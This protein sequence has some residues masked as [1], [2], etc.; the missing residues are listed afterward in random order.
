M[1][2][3]RSRIVERLDIRIIALNKVRRRLADRSLHDRRLTL[4]INRFSSMRLR[5]SQTPH[6]PEEVTND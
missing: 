6:P 2:T 3:I 4:L 5:L 1:S